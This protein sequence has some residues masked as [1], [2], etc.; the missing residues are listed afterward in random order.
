L[1]LNPLLPLV[2]KLKRGLLNF[3]IYYMLISAF[4]V[5][6]NTLCSFRFF[7]ARGIKEHKRFGVF[8][9]IFYHLLPVLHKRA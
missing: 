3:S 7:Y 9:E 1:P 8:T 6:K 5:P 2:G 4:E